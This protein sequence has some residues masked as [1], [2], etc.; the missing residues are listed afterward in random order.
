MIWLDGGPGCA[1]TFGLF[2]NIGPYEVKNFQYDPTT[3]KYT[4]D[5][6]ADLRDTSWHANY[7][8]LFADNP[9][10]VG[11]STNQD[12]YLPKNAVEVTEQ[13]VIFLINFLEKYP[14]FKGRPLVLTGASFGCHWAPFL[15][16]ALLKLKNPDINLQGLVIASGFMNSRELYQSYPKFSMEN[17]QWTKMTP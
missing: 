1:G 16:S 9:I 2:F 14:E 10:G 17:A 12:K 13:L 4:G 11:F 5:K 7:N 3:G 15:G 6:K 8:L